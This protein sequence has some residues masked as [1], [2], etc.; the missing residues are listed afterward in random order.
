MTDELFKKRKRNAD[1]E[2]PSPSSTPQSVN[3]NDSD[4]YDDDDEAKEVIDIIFDF[5]DP[6][7]VDFHGLKSLLSQTFGTTNNDTD[8]HHSISIPDLANLIISQ[9]HIGSTVKAE[10]QLDP[11]AVV[12]VINLSAHKHEHCVKALRT[13]LSERAKSSNNAE[14]TSSFTEL[15]N[16][17]ND[18]NDVGWI[19]NERLINMPPQVALPAWRMLMEEMQW[20]VEDGERYE[21]QHFVIISKTYREVES[22]VDGPQEA[23]GNGNAV[24]GKKRKSSSGASHDATS[25]PIYYFQSE[26]EIF[27][28]RCEHYFDYTFDNDS[29]VSDSR[30][31]FA[32]MGIEPARRV[33]L[34][35]KDVMKDVMADLERLL[36]TE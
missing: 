2:P 7:E 1:K 36:S 9:P 5:F 25:S 34:L 30:R 32:E 26:D 17:D 27:E 3:A 4:D 24:R 29:Q 16:K 18:D 28:K 10:E 33:F 14:A 31:V 8:V 6:K 23:N 20:A 11:Y 22:E 19:I 21:F 35:H 13:Y 12:T 15:L